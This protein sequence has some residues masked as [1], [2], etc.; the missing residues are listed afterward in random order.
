MCCYSTVIIFIIISVSNNTRSGIRTI[1]QMRAGSLRLRQKLAGFAGNLGLV[2]KG[3]KQSLLKCA[4]HLLL[5]LVI[6]SGVPNNS[7]SRIRIC[8]YLLEMRAGSSRLSQIC[9]KTLHN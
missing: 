1:L 8:V 2:K 4:P 5:F 6:I 7:R 3:P 9:P